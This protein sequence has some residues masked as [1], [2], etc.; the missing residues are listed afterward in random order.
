M[1]IGSAQVKS[2]IILSALNTPGKTIINS[3]KSRNHTEL[4]LKYLKYP[5][6]IQKKKNFDKISVEGLKQFK[7]LNMMFQEI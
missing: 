6:K 4:M 5:I 2:C 3:K 7:V 1:K